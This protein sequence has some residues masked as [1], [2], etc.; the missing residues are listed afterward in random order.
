ME[1]FEP[2]D[3][4]LR[5]ASC[6]LEARNS[7]FETNSKS[8]IRMIKTRMRQVD[9]REFRVESPRTA[10]PRLSTVDSE[11]PSTG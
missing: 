6:K 5:A 11:L 1:E 8:E 4:V 7:N 3:L 10:P 9:S 2:E